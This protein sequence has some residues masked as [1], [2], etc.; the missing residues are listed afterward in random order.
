M[1]SASDGFFDL[2]V[3]DALRPI[4]RLRWLPVIEKGKHLKLPFVNYSTVKRILIESDDLI[5]FH[6]DGEY[7]SADKMEIEILSK[8]FLFKY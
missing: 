3:I 8:K 6:L 1:A 4:K 2:V 7:Y 5:Q